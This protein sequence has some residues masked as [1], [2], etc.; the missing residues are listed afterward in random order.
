MAYPHARPFMAAALLASLTACSSQSMPNAPSSQQNVQT[1]P[2]SSRVAQLRSNVLHAANQ[3]PY[4]VGLHVIAALTAGLQQWTHEYCQRKEVSGSCPTSPGK[5]SATFSISHSGTD[6]INGGTF[7]LETSDASTLGDSTYGFD[8]TASGGQNTPGQD[9]AAVPTDNIAWFDRMHITSK[10]LPKGTPV[11]IKVELSVV[12][13]AANVS[14]TADQNSSAGFTYLATGADAHEG[15]M[16]LNGGCSA[17][18]KF[19]YTIGPNGE[20]GQGK[21]DSGVISTSVGKTVDISGSGGFNGWA[22]TFTETCVKS[23]V[24]SIAGDVI[25]KIKSIS[26]AGVTYTTNSGHMYN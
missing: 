5:T 25:W 17:P 21:T 24:T 23:Y 3:E 7:T 19:V 20:G 22:C 13:T 10:T 16:Q 12:P 2:A 1:L 15:Y 18:N 9:G 11:T 14:C 4:G 8:L 6:T 26:P